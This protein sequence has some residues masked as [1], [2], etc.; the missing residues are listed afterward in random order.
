MSVRII[1]PLPVTV[2]SPVPAVMNRLSPFFAEAFSEPAADL[3]CSVEH[4]QGIERA[5]AR[6][7]LCGA[8]KLQLVHIEILAGAQEC[9]LAALDGCGSA[10]SGGRVLSEAQGW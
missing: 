1:V 8:V 6:C 7:E 4:E 5:F 9:L 10:L 2:Y 3:K